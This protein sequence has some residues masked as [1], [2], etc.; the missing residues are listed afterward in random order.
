MPHCVVGITYKPYGVA[1]NFTPVVLAENRISI[2]VGTEVTEIDPQKNFSF[3]S[4]QRR[5][6][7]VPGHRSASPRPP[8]SWLPAAR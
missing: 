7:A 1:L 5:S 2:R 6:T 4:R 8:S 3:V